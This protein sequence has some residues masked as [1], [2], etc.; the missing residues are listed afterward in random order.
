MVQV[1]SLLSTESSFATCPPCWVLARLEESGLV[2]TVE[3]GRDRR[4]S[5]NTSALCF[6]GI[7]LPGSS[8]P[9]KDASM[10][11]RLEFS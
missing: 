5:L 11:A 3:E 2:A 10:E 6:F 4:R 7:Q 9:L 8:E 1:T